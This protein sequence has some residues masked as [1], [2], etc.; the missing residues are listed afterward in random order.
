[1]FFSKG[2]V[3]AETRDNMRGGGG[4]VILNHLADASGMAPKCR[5]F[6]E[7]VLQKDCGIGEHTHEGE[8]ELFYCIGGEGILVDDGV[9]Y[10]LL[11]GDSSA[12]LSG[13]R[14]AIR[15]E[16]DEPLRVLAMVFLD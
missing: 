8:T 2:S 14:H 5:V 7:L 6:S 9:E 16:K 3:P 11:P 15:N 4:T 10:T 12:T 1:M 13:H